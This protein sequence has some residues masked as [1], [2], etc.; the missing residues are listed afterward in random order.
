MEAGCFGH[1]F[2]LGAAHEIRAEAASEPQRRPRLR[3][4]WSASIDFLK[5]EYEWRVIVALPFFPNQPEQI[6]RADSGIPR[7]HPKGVGGRYS[8]CTTP[9]HWRSDCR[10]PSSQEALIVDRDRREPTHP[11]N[12]S[13]VT[14]RERVCTGT[15]LK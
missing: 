8:R 3:H 5:Q 6:T 7:D 14:A 11:R 1:R 15:T 12:A 13:E 4:L 2:D 9:Y 10:R